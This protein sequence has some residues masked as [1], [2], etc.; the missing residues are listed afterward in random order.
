MQLAVSVGACD[1]KLVG[2]PV[3]TTIELVQDPHVA[4][5]YPAYVHVGQ[6]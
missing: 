3:G 6:S 1:G 4:S 2:A 5:Q